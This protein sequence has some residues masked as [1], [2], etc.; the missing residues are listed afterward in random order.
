MRGRGS[1]RRGN[2]ATSDPA[3]QEQVKGLPA[4]AAVLTGAR[5]FTAIGEYLGCDMSRIAAIPGFFSNSLVGKAGEDY[6]IDPGSVSFC[7]ID[8]DILEPTR[9]VLEF[10]LDLL[11]PGALIYFDD[12]RLCRAHPEI[13]ERGAT[14]A[15]LAAHPEVDL[16]EFDRNNW[17]NQ[18]FI[19]NRRRHVVVPSEFSAVVEHSPANDYAHFCLGRS[20]EKLGDRR[21]ARRHLSLAVG[22]RPDRSDYKIYRDRVRTE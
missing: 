16:V 10:V 9:Q 1:S 15:W 17:Q 22:M 4:A 19:F 3:A 20:F 13:G 6:G 21:A 7:A 5:S 18:Y 2:H 12:W 11:E 8:C 14:L